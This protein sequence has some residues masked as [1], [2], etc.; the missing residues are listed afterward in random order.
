MMTKASQSY[1]SKNSL[2]NIWEK[3]LS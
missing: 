2:E 1:D 3:F